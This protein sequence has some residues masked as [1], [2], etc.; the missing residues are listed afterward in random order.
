MPAPVRG[1][2]RCRGWYGNIEV[3]AFPVHKVPVMFGV[4]PSLVLEFHEDP[5]LPAGPIGMTSM[6]S[7]ILSS[8]SSVRD[9]GRG[10]FDS[11]TEEP[12]EDGGDGDR[13]R[14]L[15]VETGS[16]RSGTS[17]NIS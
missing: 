2:L 9:S 6:A 13:E 1:V 4:R 14:C 8:S 3:L 10:N 7:S 11:D 12:E 16:E 17:S 15:E 5:A